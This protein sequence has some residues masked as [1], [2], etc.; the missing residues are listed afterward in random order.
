MPKATGSASIQENIEVAPSASN[1]G[2]TPPPIGASTTTIYNTYNYNY[3]IGGGN[4]EVVV[5]LVVDGSIGIDGTSVKG[6]DMALDKNESLRKELL[7]LVKSY[8]SEYDYSQ[9]AFTPFGTR[10]NRPF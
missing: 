9:R 4:G 6:T 1:G 5:R 8:I 3:G 7:D 10:Y 2:V